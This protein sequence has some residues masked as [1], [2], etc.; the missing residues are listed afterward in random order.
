M[1][2]DEKLSARILTFLLIT[3]QKPQQT[4]Q[5]LLVNIRGILRSKYSQKPQVTTMHHLNSTLELIISTVV[6]FPSDG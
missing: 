3:D 5:E 1:R 6:K 4:F 2:G